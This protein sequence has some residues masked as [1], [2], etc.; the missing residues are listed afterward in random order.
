[1]YSSPTKFVLNNVLGL[2]LAFS[3]AKS[4]MG[5][6]LEHK[7]SWRILKVFAQECSS[8]DLLLILIFYGKVKFDFW[9]F[10]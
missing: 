9:S 8:A 6:K 4:D 3:T 5:K 7:I 1:M 2:T 10:V